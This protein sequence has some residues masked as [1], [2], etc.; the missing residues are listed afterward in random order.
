VLRELQ[1]EG[2]LL[3]TLERQQPVYHLTVARAA[4]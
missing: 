4:R 1:S 3:V 2:V